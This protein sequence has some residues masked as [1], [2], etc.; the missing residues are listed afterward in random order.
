MMA[1]GVGMGVDDGEVENDG[2]ED[3][4]LNKQNNNQQ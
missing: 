4:K 1:D 3:G 2:N